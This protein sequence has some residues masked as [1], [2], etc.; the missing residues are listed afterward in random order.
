[1]EYRIEKDTLGEVKVPKNAYYGAQTQRA[2][3]NFPISGQRLQPCFIR[4]QAIIKLAAAEAN[5]ACGQLDKRIGKAIA[6]AAQEVLKGNYQ[7][8]SILLHILKL[9]KNYSHQLRTLDKN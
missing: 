6:K 9:M 4:A 1:M 7:D 8:L 5:M 2:I 3:E